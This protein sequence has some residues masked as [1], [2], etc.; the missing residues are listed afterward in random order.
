M[1][2]IRPPSKGK[3]AGSEVNTRTLLRVGVAGTAIAALCCVTPLPVV[4]L[5]VVG[6]SAW[7]GA[8]DYVL[9]PALVVLVA[10]T[11]YAMKRRRDEAACCDAPGQGGA[12]A[13]EGQR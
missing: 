6:L 9:I 1:P 3:R 4:L 5:G 2:A 12:H 11:L 7:A 13:P 10:L 8:L